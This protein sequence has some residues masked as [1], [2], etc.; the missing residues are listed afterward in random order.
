MRV[1]DQVEYPFPGIVTS[2]C[3]QEGERNNYHCSLWDEYL[4]LIDETGIN[5]KVSTKV[6][7]GVTDFIIKT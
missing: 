1:I 7:L 3:I 6:L 5:K 4:K 2:Q